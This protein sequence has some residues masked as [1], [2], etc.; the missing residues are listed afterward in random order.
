M[1]PFQFTPPHSVVDMNA[2]K[3]GNSFGNGNHSPVSLYI[4]AVRRVVRDF[5]LSL[6]NVDGGGAGRLPDAMRFDLFW[7]SLGRYYQLSI[8]IIA[9]KQQG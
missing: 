5:D 8:T 7:E 2:K 3:T 9:P 1:I 6:K 4:T